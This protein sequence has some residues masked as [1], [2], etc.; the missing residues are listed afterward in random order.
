MSQHC[1]K[2]IF[3][4]L[5]SVMRNVRLQWCSDWGLQQ[6]SQEH[7]CLY[8]I[9]CGLFPFPWRPKS[10]LYWLTAGVIV[11]VIRKWRY[12]GSNGPGVR[13]G[14]CLESR[15]WIRDPPPG[16]E[17]SPVH[18]Y[19]VSLHYNAHVD[20]IAKMT[21]QVVSKILTCT[22]FRRDVHDL[23]SSLSVMQQVDE[24]RHVKL[25]WHH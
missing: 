4:N 7:Y 24:G 14:L 11:M 10:I 17:V 19:L 12:F 3:H 21:P 15:A 16:L 8:Y 23:S 20:L 18:N 6:G 2:S 22:L 13:D 9:S 1:C 25:P 5:Y